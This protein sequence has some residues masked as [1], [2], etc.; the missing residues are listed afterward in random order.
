MANL[1]ATW[2]PVPPC[3]RVTHIHARTTSMTVKAASR[4]NFDDKDKDRLA[5]ASTYKIPTPNE[6]PLHIPLTHGQGPSYN[7]F[8]GRNLALELV[9]VTESAALRC[10]QWYGRGDKIAADQAA[11]DGMRAVLRHIKMKGTIVIGEGEKDEAPMLYNGEMV[12]DGSS[13]EVD[14]AV[15]PVDGTTMTASG[16]PGAVSVIAVA[17]KGAMFNPGPVVY[18][19]KLVVPEEVHASHVH[20]DDPI[21][22]TIRTVAVAKKKAV[23]D[24]VV[25]ILQRPR[26]EKIINEVRAAGAR[27][28]LIVDG[29]VAASL[30]VSKHGSGVDMVVGTGGSPEG[31]ITACALRA[32]GAHMQARLAPRDEEER[33][34]AIV[35]HG[36]A[37]RVDRVMHTADLCG[38][39]ELYFAATGVTD[40]EFLRGVH[41]HM[42]GASTHSMVVRNLSGTVRYM[43]THHK[44]AKPSITNPRF[45]QQADILMSNE[46]EEDDK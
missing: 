38:G 18:M 14:V 27:V 32:L 44:W 41:F 3:A 12:G 20:L 2:R 46:G 4:A 35:F 36:S 30:A 26:H 1:C 21:S 13:P 22:Q 28:K 6:M 25:C 11:V 17:E 40:G 33:K 19:E 43:D 15:D 23:E 9:R 42:G 10:S 34:A 16:G 45:Q 37:D 5:S 29:D 8:E 24:V 31:V 39:K 7:F